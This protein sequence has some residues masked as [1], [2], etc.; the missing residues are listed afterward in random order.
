[1]CVPRIRMPQPAT[2]AAAPPPPGSSAD[3]MRT[4]ERRQSQ[5]GRYGQ[6][7]ARSRRT[8]RTD[9]NMS[10]QSGTNIPRMG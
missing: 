2:P 1:M 7:V 10:G 8:L 6:G 4:Q 3:F 9:V 5:D